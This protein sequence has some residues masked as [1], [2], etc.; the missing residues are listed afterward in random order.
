MFKSYINNF[1]NRKCLYYFLECTATTLC[2]FQNKILIAAHFLFHFASTFHNLLVHVQTAQYPEG[3][4][5]N[6]IYTF[7]L[8]IYQYIYIDDSKKNFVGLEW[9][10]IFGITGWL[11]TYLRHCKKWCHWHSKYPKTDISTIKVFLAH[12][13]H[14]LHNFH[15]TWFCSTLLA[16]SLNVQKCNIKLDFSVTCYRRPGLVGTRGQERDGLAKSIAMTKY[17]ELLQ[18]STKDI[19]PCT[20]TQPKHKE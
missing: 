18:G 6:I 3:N 20:P 11:E 4:T 14:W 1:L 13:N 17:Y 8:L 15:E 19:H 16:H 9:S 2:L 10:E 7:Y 12:S 5:C